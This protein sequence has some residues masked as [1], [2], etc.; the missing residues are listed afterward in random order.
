MKQLI[1]AKT[2]DSGLIEPTH[3]VEVVCAACGYDLDE[4]ELETDTCSDCKAPLNLRQHISIH[5]TSV[6]AAG[7]EVF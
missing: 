4:S 6:P 3:E 7:G 2:L 1:Q 5:A